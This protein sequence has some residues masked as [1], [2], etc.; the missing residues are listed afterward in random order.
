MYLADKLVI[1]KKGSQIGLTDGKNPN[2][3][4]LPESI[5]V[6]EHQVVDL[7]VEYDKKDSIP[8]G[9]NGAQNHILSNK[10]N[11]CFKKS[12]LSNNGTDGKSG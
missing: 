1:E 10:V 7:V 12:G 11:L 9:K 3:I 5:T 4:E 8:Y 6:T 2:K